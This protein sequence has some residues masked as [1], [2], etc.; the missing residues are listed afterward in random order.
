MGPNRNSATTIGSWLATGGGDVDG[1]DPA[2]SLLQQ[3]KGSIGDTTATST[4]HLFEAVQDVIGG[5]DAEVTHDDGVA[6]FRNGAPFAGVLGPTRPVAT[7][8]DA[9]DRGRFALL[10]VATNS[11]PSV[12]KVE[13]LAT[14]GALRL[15]RKAA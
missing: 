13:G 8:L 9:F 15:R 14:I 5:A 2:F 11:D 6:I 1:L 10:Y 12:L 3:S 7:G 4:F